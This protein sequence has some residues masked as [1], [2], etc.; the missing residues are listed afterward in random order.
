MKWLI[1]VLLVGAVIAV[2]VLF[3]GGG[4]NYGIDKSHPLGNLEVMSEYLA[5]KKLQ[6]LERELKWSDMFPMTEPHEDF[7]QEDDWTVVE[8]KDSAW[9]ETGVH[10]YV[11]FLV[12]E[13]GG[14][15]AS[16][17]GFYSG[18]SKYATVGT[19]AEVFLARYWLAIVKSKP[20]FELGNEPGIKLD[21][22]LNT[23]VQRGRVHGNWRKKPTTGDAKHTRSIYD[24]IV[25]W[26][27]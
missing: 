24:H 22:F 13:T 8:F 14:I 26:I 2:P 4:S 17:G 9:Q 6:R 16:G 1:G 18:T 12:D 3:L 10:H 21:E 15:R 7:K 27:D 20:K 23:Q 25:F 5:G 11:F 19:K